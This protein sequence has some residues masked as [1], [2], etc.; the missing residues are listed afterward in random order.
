MRN[1]PFNSATIQHVGGFPL[2]RIP[3]MDNSEG[4]HSYEELADLREKLRNQEEMAKTTAE[5]TDCL[6]EWGQAMEA[7]KNKTREA[8]EVLRDMFN[9][10]A[11]KEVTVDKNIAARARGILADSPSDEDATSAEEDN[12][13][14]DTPRSLPSPSHNAASSAEE[15]NKEEGNSKKEGG[16][17]N[18]TL[19]PATDDEGM[20]SSV[21][22]EDLPLLRQTSGDSMFMNVTFGK[23]E[24]PSTIFL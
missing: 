13:L 20:M 12:A 11:R 14:S 4:R 21:S 10:C 22:H 6:E 24:V 18:I 23:H 9:M 2:K 1:V 7:I 15:D 17:G 3:V 16:Y 19:G 8:A 5:M